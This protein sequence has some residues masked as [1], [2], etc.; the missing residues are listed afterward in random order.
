MEM[1]DLK[2]IHMN[3]QRYNKKYLKK[4]YPEF[5]NIILNLPGEKITEKIYR[6]FYP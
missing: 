2:D 1:P 6:Y 3:P 4:V 5:L